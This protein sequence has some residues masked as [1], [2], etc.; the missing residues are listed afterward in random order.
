MNRIAEKGV[1]VVSL[2]EFDGKNYL[3]A[4]AAVSVAFGLEE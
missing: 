4:L 2:L 1:F 3:V